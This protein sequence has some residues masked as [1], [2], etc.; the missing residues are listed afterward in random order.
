MKQ[1]AL[2]LFSFAFSFAPFAPSRDT[3]GFYEF[4][5]P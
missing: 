3:S 4:S 2:V 5:V 1:R